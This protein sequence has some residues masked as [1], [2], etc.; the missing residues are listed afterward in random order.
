MGDGIVMV[1]PSSR[2]PP[3]RMTTTGAVAEALGVTIEDVRRCA[4]D[5]SRG[6]LVG[7]GPVDLPLSLLRSRSSRTKMLVPHANAIRDAMPEAQARWAELRRAAEQRAEERLT[8]AGAAALAGVS[9]ATIRK[10]A[11]RGYIHADGKAG[12]SNTYRRGDVEAAARQA[13]LREPSG[14]TAAFYRL[15]AHERTGEVTTETAARIFDVTPATI[16]K[17]VSRGRL[18]PVRRAGRS[19]VFRFPDLVDLDRTRSRRR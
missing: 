12:R 13:R 19:H 8:T 15:T 5:L 2:V 4:S 17:W 18:V 14:P 10:W 9:A 11:E 3:V 1:A 16:R 6:L 7:V